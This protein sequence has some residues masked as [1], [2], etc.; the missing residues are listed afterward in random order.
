MLIAL[1]IL[2]AVGWIAAAVL[3]RSTLFWSAHFD[4]Q[5]EAAARMIDALQE[6]EE[7]AMSADKLK[8]VYV[9]P[10]GVIGERGSEDLRA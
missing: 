2:A 8:G 9:V 4:M 3:L 1:A 6:A 10:P 7:R 5:K